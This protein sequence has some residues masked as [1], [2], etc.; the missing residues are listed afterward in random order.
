MNAQDGTPDR[1]ARLLDALTGFL[2]QWTMAVQSLREIAEAAGVSKTTVS[3]ALRGNARIS[4]EQR[5]RIQQL[6]KRMGYRPDPTIARIAANGWKSSRRRGGVPIAFVMGME[7]PSKHAGQVYLNGAKRQGTALGYKVERHDLADY[8]SPERLSQV[9]STRGYEGLILFQIQNQDFCDRFDWDKFSSVAC[10]LSRVSLPTQLVSPD[11]V[12][13]SEESWELLRRRD[14]KRI[15]LALLRQ[16]N[17]LDSLVRA[18]VF[19]FH[20]HYGRARLP[21]IPPMAFD[22]DYNKGS[23]EFLAWVARNKPDVIVG[24]TDLFLWWLVE[25]G[26]RVPEDIGFVSLLGGGNLRGLVVSGWDW[27]ADALGAASM[28]QLDLQIRSGRRGKNARANT[29]MLPS[30]W[31][32]GATL[33]P[34]P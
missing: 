27:N 5:E 2:D 12:L 11:F 7:K 33:R 34:E 10:T 30:S 18:G 15:G 17:D 4:A 16:S 13:Q 28:E 3:L 21:K 9:L 19:A 6:A 8:G 25:A 24:L 32:E 22:A 26:I 14:Y 23:A 31:I 1:F 29:L 20:E